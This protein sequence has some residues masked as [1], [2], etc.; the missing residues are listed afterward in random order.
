MYKH[1]VNVSMIKDE[2]IKLNLLLKYDIDPLN[3]KKDGLV[4]ANRRIK[5]ETVFNLSLREKGKYYPLI[6]YD[7]KKQVF[8][9]IVTM[10]V[11]FQSMDKILLGGK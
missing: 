6:Q 7:N 4:I 11:Y 1:N 5:G 10:L 9:A 8:K 3:N 2:L